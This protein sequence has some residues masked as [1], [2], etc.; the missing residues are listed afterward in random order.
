EDGTITLIGATTENPSFEL[1][2][3]LL[4]RLR[5][6]TLQPLAEEDLRTIALR[7]F[8]EPERGLGLNPEQLAPEALDLLVQLAGG[9]ARSALNTLE[10]AMLAARGAGG[11]FV[12]GAAEV[13]QAAQQTGQYDRKGEHHYDTISAFIKTI[14][15]SNPDAAL[16][17]LARML[18]RGEDPRFIARRLL[19]LA[20]E[21]VGN[22]DPQAL[23]LAVAAMQACQLLGMPEAAYPLSQVTTYLALAPKSNAAKGIFAAMDVERAHPGAAVPVHLRN[24]PTKLMKELGYGQAY[25]YPHD[26]PGGIVAQNYWPE[27]LNPVQFYKPSDRG[28]ESELRERRQAISKAFRQ[29]TE[30]S[31]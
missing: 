19:I 17:W 9:D 4:S 10:A 1:N 24:A 3:A 23:T 18:N 29:S 2:A 30:E 27:G 8:T 20:S 14:R 12:V 26:F 16:Y 13:A 7:A 25:R 22:A 11:P 31:T 21:D 15:G 5:V 28:F 6:L